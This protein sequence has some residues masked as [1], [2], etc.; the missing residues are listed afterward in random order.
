MR[1]SRYAPRLACRSCIAQ[2]RIS[3]SPRASARRKS[4]AGAARISRSVPTVARPTTISTCSASCEA[5]LCWRRRSRTPRFDPA[6]IEAHYSHLE[7]LQEQG[8]LEAFGPFTDKSGGA[9][10]VRAESLDEARAMAFADPVHATG[11]SIVTVRE[12]DLK[13]AIQA[14]EA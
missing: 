9:Y 12:W 11:S 2:N 5:P 14:Q 10:L 7:A 3:S 6:V 8:A 4:C 13:F 1:K